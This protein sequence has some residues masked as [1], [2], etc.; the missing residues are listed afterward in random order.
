MG[1]DKNLNFPCELFVS[2]AEAVNLWGTDQEVGSIL[3]GALRRIEDIVIDSSRSAK[4]KLPPNAQSLLPQSSPTMTP[5]QL[6]QSLIRLA[7]MIPENAHTYKENTPFPEKLRLSRTGQMN[8]FGPTQRS[9]T[10]LG[11]RSGL[12]QDDDYTLVGRTPLKDRIEGTIDPAAFLNRSRFDRDHYRPSSRP[13]PEPAPTKPLANSAFNNTMTSNTPSFQPTIKKP[14]IVIHRVSDNPSTTFQNNTTVKPSGN[15]VSP[16]SATR[17]TAPLAPLPTTIQNYSPSSR[18]S[19]PVFLSFNPHPDSSQTPRLPS[20]NIQNVPLPSPD[21]PQTYQGPGDHSSKHRPLP[22]SP[23]QTGLSGLRSYDS[24]Q[25]EDNRARQLLSEAIR[26]P[27]AENRQHTPTRNNPWA[28]PD[29]STTPNVF[30]AQNKTVV[31]V[32]YYQPTKDKDVGLDTDEEDLPDDNSAVPGG[33]GSGGP[34]NNMRDHRGNDSASHPGHRKSMMGPQHSVIS[35]NSRKARAGNPVKLEVTTTKPIEIRMVGI[36]APLSSWENVQNGEPLQPNG[37]PQAQP[38][39]DVESLANES[40]MGVPAPGTGVLTP[41]TSGRQ[42]GSIRTLGVGRDIVKIDWGHPDVE[43]DLI[44]EYSPSKKSRLSKVE[45]VGVGLSKISLASLDFRSDNPFS[46]IVC[47]TE[48]RLTGMSG[49]GINILQ[50][51]DLAITPQQR[52]RI[53]RV[54]LDK[55]SALLKVFS[56]GRIVYSDRM[57]NSL[58]LHDI[59]T[60]QDLRVLKGSTY[61]RDL[62]DRR[63]VLGYT[64]N[65]DAVLWRR[66]ETTLAIVHLTDFEIEKEIANFWPQVSPEQ[67]SDCQAISDQNKTTILGVSRTKNHGTMVSLHTGGARVRHVGLTDLFKSAHYASAICMLNQS[68]TPQPLALAV[69]RV[70]IKH[71]LVSLKLQP[72][73]SAL[74]GL[75]LSVDPDED[76]FSIQKVGG[77]SEGIYILA[78][79][80]RLLLVSASPNGTLVPLDHLCMFTTDPLV[81]LWS[82]VSRPRILLLCKRS[83]SALDILPENGSDPFDDDVGRLEGK[84]RHKDTPSPPKEVKPISRTPVKYEAYE[85][86]ALKPI[87]KELPVEKNTSSDV[88]QRV[89][90]PFDIGRVRRLAADPSHDRLF[91]AGESVAILAGTG[92][93]FR[94]LDH[95]GHFSAFALASLGAGTL[96]L[97]DS[98]SHDL[99]VADR[100][101]KEVGRYKGVPPLAVEDRPNQKYVQQ[102]ERGFIWL[103]GATRV[104]YVLPDMT[105]EDLRIFDGPFVK[106]FSPIIK[107]ALRTSQARLLMA[108]SLSGKGQCLVSAQEGLTQVTP[109]N[110]IGG[111]IKTLDAICSDPDRAV[112]LMGGSSHLDKDSRQACGILVV[113]SAEGKPRALHTLSLDPSTQTVTVIKV[114]KPGVYAVG[115]KGQVC[116]VSLQSQQGLSI[117]RVLYHHPGMTVSDICVF[118]GSIFSVSETDDAIWATPLD[119]LANIES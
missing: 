57:M 56:D 99:I 36:E 4:Q 93:S 12:Q 58:H 29:P 5:A 3:K 79:Q 76:F 86:P 51:E 33:P 23:E 113:T 38:A 88:A 55:P 83:V 17:S 77:V 62:H 118:R 107:L 105:I 47:D 14:E 48:G 119:F 41:A 92:G 43:R 22:P 106:Q 82:V 49:Q 87:F 94:L 108:V 65:K 28:D 74:S 2:L 19:S 103:A 50:T 61:S 84:D 104:C 1:W 10:P 18:D 80:R 109:I 42:A 95:R 101:L 98:G 70:G 20:K 68:E 27:K 6:K 16:F 116:V 97:S 63:V 60:G 44:K 40:M 85:M 35:K 11:T 15:T 31:F 9:R 34:N 69:L 32:P 78:S 96:L 13:K 90:L 81:S 89:V 91:L 117:V 37:Q 30:E 71:I 64:P 53:N 72:Y 75:H 46:R 25:R 24:V 100:D 114:L 52:D 73:L 21:R 8:D 102:P 112:V 110:S 66:S 54:L 45:T 26:A 111:G 7:N 67:F 39:V 59:N 115:C